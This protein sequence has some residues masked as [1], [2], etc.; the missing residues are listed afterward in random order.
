MD[1]DLLSAGNGHDAGEE[2]NDFNGGPV[3][4]PIFDRVRPTFI[5]LFVYSR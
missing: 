1:H 5:L 2:P 3:V 4:L